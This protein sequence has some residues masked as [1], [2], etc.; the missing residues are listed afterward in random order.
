[1]N[2]LKQHLN[3][4]KEFYGDQRAERSGVLWMEH[5]YEGIAIMEELGSSEYAKAAY[6]VHPIFQTPEGLKDRL[7]LLDFEKYDTQ[8][9]FLAMEYRNKANAYLCRPK[10]DNYKIEDLPVLVLSET[11]DMLIADKVQNYKDF[12][13]FHLG[14]HKRSQFLNNYF[15]LWLKHLGISKQEFQRLSKIGESKGTASLNCDS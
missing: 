12:L 11:R 7:E 9:V 15:L 4:I 6:A 3:I 2:I 1:M 8:V 5:I 10:T 14:T 13:K